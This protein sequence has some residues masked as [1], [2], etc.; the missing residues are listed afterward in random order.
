MDFCDL[1]F[2][3]NGND[4]DM[5]DPEELA[6]LIRRL[7]IE[8]HR[9][10]KCPEISVDELTSLYRQAEALL[11]HTQE[12]RAA[13]LHRWLRNAIRAIDAR[14]DPDRNADLPDCHP[15]LERRMRTP[16]SRLDSSDPRPIG[17][18]KGIMQKRN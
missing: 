15:E 17:S 11:D 8:T 9:A 7:A 5:L 6:R 3:L 4:P 12:Q 2:S 14:L 10:L 1:D 18:H 16:G 13:E